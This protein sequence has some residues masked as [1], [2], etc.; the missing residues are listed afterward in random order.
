M[1]MISILSGKITDNF[2]IGLNLI[3]ESKEEVYDALT[4]GIAFNKTL[5]EKD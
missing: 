5:W 2:E 3:Y 4:F 1:I